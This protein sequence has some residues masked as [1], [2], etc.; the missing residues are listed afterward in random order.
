M[1]YPL[2][3]EGRMTTLPRAG[4]GSEGDPAHSQSMPSEA[5]SPAL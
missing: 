5:G 2:S 3:Y 1:L 4:R